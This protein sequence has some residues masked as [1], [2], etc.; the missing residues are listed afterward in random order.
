M[1]VSN[2]LVR[3]LREY[4]KAS[5][6]AFTEHP[7]A[8]FIRNDLPNVVA[9]EIGSSDRFRV[10]GSA[11]QGRWV[12]APWIGIFNRIVTDT[13]QRGYYPAILFREDMTGV[14]LSLNQ[15]MTEAK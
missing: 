7:L 6:E 11:G 15:G 12:N 13:A 14:Y 4:A 5:K 10:K 1:Q 2:G 8:D 3:V 9:S